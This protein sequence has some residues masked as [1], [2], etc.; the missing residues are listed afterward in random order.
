MA[1]SGKNDYDLKLTFC[2][3]YGPIGGEFIP[4]QPCRKMIREAST[5]T[6]TSKVIRETPSSNDEERE[7][8]SASGIL[9]SLGVPTLAE[10]PE[11]LVE[12]E[13]LKE[14]LSK[15]ATGK[16]EKDE[17]LKLSETFWQTARGEA[18]HLVPEA[19]EA[20]WRR[21][22]IGRSERVLA[23]W[24]ADSDIHQL[25][26]LAQQMIAFAKE[27]R[28]SLN[29]LKLMAMTAGLLG[30]LRPVRARGLL[31]LILPHLEHHPSLLVW[32]SQ[33]QS[34]TEAGHLL[35]EPEMKHRVLWNVRLRNPTLEWS[36][37]TPEAREA[38]GDLPRT[39]MQAAPD[40]RGLFQAT[41]PNF[42]WDLFMQ[43]ESKSTVPA[44]G[45]VVTLAA[46]PAHSRLLLGVIVGCV[47][48]VTL[49]FAWLEGRRAYLPSP[50]DAEVQRFA[51][52]LET[53]QKKPIAETPPSAPPQVAM[54]PQASESN[55]TFADWR[56]ERI[57][58]IREE[59]PAIERLHLVLLTGTLAEAEPILRGGSSI[60]A[61]GS[62]AHQA[63]LRWAVLSPPNDADVRRA[64]IRLFCLTLPTRDTFDL[65]ELLAGEG[66]LHGE[67]FRRMAGLMLSAGAHG[68]AEKEQIQLSRIAKSESAMTTGKGDAK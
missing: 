62:T 44:Q 6:K 42:W 54:P 10:G 23:V 26:K 43:Q 9:E 41:V 27:E 39:L 61:V 30:I 21:G 16:L 14:W 7:G 58:A 56:Q 53:D 60:A 32:V 35:M 19:L 12:D 31:D 38:L 46:Q 29:F 65:M 59:F 2:G 48:G 20:E 50:P 45:S 33:A 18:D 67:E 1:K 47:V 4:S 52:V 64:V 55:E 63:L 57:D 22:E 68:L 5:P 8:A 51:P 13:A 15:A 24:I 17:T 40:V 37:E 11:S 49:S 36:W 28:P 34:W 25:A 3:Q 66:E